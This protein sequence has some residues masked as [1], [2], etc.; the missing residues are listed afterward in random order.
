[1]L[2]LEKVAVA[3]SSERSLTCPAERSRREGRHYERESGGSS[4]GLGSLPFD[5]VTL[6]FARK[7]HRRLRICLSL[8]A[9][10]LVLARCHSR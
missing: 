1:M 10:A 7:R 5:W 3:S 2:P 4:F 8:M 6:N 9:T